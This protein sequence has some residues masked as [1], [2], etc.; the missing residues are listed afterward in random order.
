M[1]KLGV[2]LVVVGLLSGVVGT[3]GRVSMAGVLLDADGVM[4]V[5][6]NPKRRRR[7][8]WE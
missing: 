7:C 1:V 8:G 5:G 6:V 4:L 2:L 3:D